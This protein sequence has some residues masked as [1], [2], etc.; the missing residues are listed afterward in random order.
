MMAYKMI[1][2]PRK[3]P[4]I[5][6]KKLDSLIE[7]QKLINRVTHLNFYSKVLTFT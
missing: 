6:S 2:I 5:N 4:V 3:Q 1:S 7:K